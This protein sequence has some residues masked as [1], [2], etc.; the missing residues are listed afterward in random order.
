ML[1][2]NVAAQ[3]LS[4]LPLQ[5]ALQP[6]QLF[7]AARQLVTWHYQWMVLHD[8]L[9]TLLHRGSVEAALA[10]PNHVAG[11]NQVPLEFS[12]AALRFG[13]SM[14]SA[15]YDFNANFG[16]G[17]TV[18]RM[19]SLGDMFMFTSRSRMGGS[20]SPQLPNHWVPDWKRLTQARSG[21]E[22]VDSVL[23]APMLTSLG[24]GQNQHHGSIA[25]RNLLR[26][27]HRR[28][29]FGQDIARRLGIEPLPVEAMQRM[30]PKS[31]DGSYDHAEMAAKTPA[32]FYFL[33]EAEALDDGKCAGP[34]A[35]RIIAETMV[36]LM[37]HDPQ[38]LLNAGRN[39]S[40]DES[41]L[42]TPADR[43]VDSIIRMLEFARLMG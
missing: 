38:S 22:P 36:G 25:Y 24:A 28:I 2:H 16:V 10:S 39:W 13:H 17:G 3:S 6:R 43:P 26:G 40:P 41:P 5:A 32:W 14:V 37:R 34:T 23:A 15:T 18:D 8:F 27:F 19:A 29:P 20:Q 9:P 35:S 31:D 7:D 30:L 42:R 4:E 33:C 11:A 21:A 12:T 1:F